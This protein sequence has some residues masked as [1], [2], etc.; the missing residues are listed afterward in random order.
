MK[1]SEILY[2][3][4]MALSYQRYYEIADRVL[5]TSLSIGPKPS[6]RAIQRAAI[7]A[8][9]AGRSALCEALTE[10]ANTPEDQRDPERLP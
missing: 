7:L 10:A 6:G 3:Q 1:L 2:P 5:G 8:A 9:T 4:A